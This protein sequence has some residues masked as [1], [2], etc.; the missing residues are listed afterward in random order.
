MSGI[1]TP[2]SSSPVSAPVAPE[3]KGVW[4][5]AGEKMREI[6]FFQDGDS[7]FTKVSKVALWFI[8]I[9]TG[10]IVA[11]AIAL[12]QAIKAYRSN[13]AEAPSSEVDSRINTLNTAV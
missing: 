10:G 2:V 8:S 4:A 11:G 13:N 7:F 5:V 6:Y 3:Q 1:T 9:V 12:T